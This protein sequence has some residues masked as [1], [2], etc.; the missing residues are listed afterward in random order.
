V[1]VCGLPGTGKT[2]ISI[3]LAK[4]TNWLA[5]STDKIKKE[6]I[7]NPTYSVEEKRLIYD[8]L[9]LIAKY[10]HKSGTNCILDAT[11]NTKSKKD[12]HRKQRK[13]ECLTWSPA[14]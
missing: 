9:V 11:C 13:I 1:P 8:V 2:S 10:L 3:E 6:L 5:L 7:S 14:P 4:L 12:G